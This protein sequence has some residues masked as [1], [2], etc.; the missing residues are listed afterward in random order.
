MK[1]TAFVG[2]AR[3]KHTFNATEYFLKIL[4]SL[5]NVEC[6]I[7]RLSDYKLEICKGCRTCFDKGEEKCPL[8]DDRD[9]LL[10]KMLSSDGIVLATPN[11]SF[12]L[13][14]YMKVFLDRLGFAFHRPCFFGKAFTSIVVQGFYRGNKIIKYFN[15]F[16][17]YLG[18]NVING[19]CLNSLE[20]ITEIEQSKINNILDRHAKKYYSLLIGKKYP[21]PSIAQ[22]MIFRMSR[23]SIRLLLNESWKDYIYYKQ[24]GWFD[25]NYFYNT[26]LSLFKKLLGKLFDWIFLKI[27]SKKITVQQT[28]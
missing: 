18:F 9:I 27:Y 7:I 28:V 16:A 15:F 4:Q 14:G 26:Q 10:E 19:S 3:R 5:G 11:Y 25:S 6:E 1:V 23:T 8:K 13:S 21:T 22:L 17:K 12:D 24:K 2:S 20:P